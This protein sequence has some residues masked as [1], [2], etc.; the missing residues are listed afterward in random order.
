MIQRKR[1]REEHVRS[2]MRVFGASA[3]CDVAAMPQDEGLVPPKFLGAGRY[4]KKRR[5]VLPDVAVTTM[6]P[7]M[8]VRQASIF[9]ATESAQ[10]REGSGYL[11]LAQCGAQVAPSAAVPTKADGGA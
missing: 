2:N 9:A 8:P 6:A 11:V 7:N 1:R 4:T 10:R 3:E 5:R